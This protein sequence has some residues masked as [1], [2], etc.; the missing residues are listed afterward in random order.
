MLKEVLSRDGTNPEGRMLRSS[1]MLAEGKGSDAAKEMEE[2]STLYP[3]NLGVKMALARS[4]LAN[5][6]PIRAAA[7][8]EEGSLSL[9]TAN[10]LGSAPITITSG[11]LAFSADQSNA[12]VV[13]GTV[14]LNP[15]GNPRAMNGA[16]SGSGSIN[17]TNTGTN[18]L[19]LGGGMSTFA[20][21]LSLGSSTGSVRLYGNTGSAT[22]AFDLGS[23]TVTLHTR[24]GGTTINLGSLTGGTGTKLSGASSVAGTTIFS[25]G[26]TNA[27]TTFA[28]SITN[29]SLGIT[30][31]TALAKTGTGTFTL[32]GNSSHTGPAAINNGSLEL[33]GTFGTSPV[34]V[35]AN[36]VLSGTGTLGGSLTTAAGGVISPGANN[37][38]S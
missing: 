23:S 25:V 27:S 33:L 10:A 38:A 20:G 8:L 7:T 6:D 12:L 28:G 1:A 13:D 22:T 16:W 32:T 24:N 4:F 11:T 19:T 30:A 31:P 26:A 34:T 3:G 36:A 18:L 5:N 29:G 21:D 17:I 14:A 37:G 2:L 15:S 35:G 9:T